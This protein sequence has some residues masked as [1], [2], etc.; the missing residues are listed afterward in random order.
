[1]TTKHVDRSYNRLANPVLEASL[2]DKAYSA[3]AATFIE[4]YQLGDFEKKFA[5]L[6]KRGRFRSLFPAYCS[7]IEAVATLPVFRRDLPSARHIAMARSHISNSCGAIEA[8]IHCR[9]TYEAHLLSGRYIEAIECLDKFSELHGESLWY[10]RTKILALARQGNSQLLQKFCDDVKARAKSHLVSTFTSYFQIIADADDA[11]LMLK[12]VILKEAEEFR[13]SGNVDLSAIISLYFSPAGMQVWRDF[14]AAIPLLQL[15]PVV[16]QYILLT[17]IL[18]AVSPA[19]YVRAPRPD[20]DVLRT[21]RSL[22]TTVSD[23]RLTRA[24]ALISSTPEH[25]TTPTGAALLSLYEK[26]RYGEVIETYEERYSQLVNPLAFSNVI[27]KALAYSGLTQLT[28]RR[29]IAAE[30]TEHL[31]R[32]QSLDPTQDHSTNQAISLAIQTKGLTLS[33]QVQAAL[34]MAAPLQRDPEDRRYIAALALVESREV[35]PRLKRLAVGDSKP[36]VLPISSEDDDAVPRYRSRKREI[37]LAIESMVEAGEIERLFSLYKEEAPLRRE[38]IELYA[39]YC[40]VNNRLPRLIELCGDTLTMD[41]ESYACFPM[42]AIIDYIDSNRVITLQALVAAFFHTK[43]GINRRDYLLNEMLEEYL[44]QREVARPS[45]LLM[46]QT[47]LSPIERL[48]YK[49]ICT[50]DVIDF[51]GCFESLNDLR[52]ERLLIVDLLLERGAIESIDRMREV[53]EIVGQ[54]IVDT[55]ASDLN[56]AKIYVDE[57]SIKRKLLPEVASS[58]LLYRQAKN[59]DDDRITLLDGAGRDE[60]TTSVYLSGSKNSIAIRLFNQLLHSFLFDERYGLDKNLST[61]IRHGFFSNLIRSKCEERH[62]LTESN[63]EGD[64]TPNA[65]WRDRYHFL[66]DEVWF[67]IDSSLKSFSSAF[68]ALVSKAEEWMKI[69][70]K[71]GQDQRVFAFDLE[72]NEFDDFRRDLD[73]CRG[74]EDLLDRAIRRLW[75]KTELV[76]SQI[77]ERLNV[78]FK[79]EMDEVFE[80]LVEAVTDAKRGAPLVELMGVIAQTKSDIKEDITRA[81]EWFR[82]SSEAER[83]SLPLTAV[84]GIAVSAFKEVRS[85]SLSIHT[86]IAAEIKGVPVKGEAV[87]PLVL[88]LINLL[89]NALRHSGLGLA[90]DVNIV[91]S[92]TDENSVLIEVSNDLSEAKL[93]AVG[94]HLHHLKRLLEVSASD[95]RLRTEGGSGLGKVRTLVDLTGPGNSVDLTLRG[96]RFIV[97]VR[98]D[99]DEAAAFD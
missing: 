35:T 8:L 76:M 64:Y 84:I 27:A 86:D 40:I 31:S 89:D 50:P 92:V 61:E 58:L 68:N 26:G 98:Y 37:V 62:L 12:N 73:E 75:V 45:E 97:G 66:L 72:L 43:K 30:L 18:C 2:P 46:G 69:R 54:I 82:R 95:P 39:E 93:Q 48:F 44:L 24:I 47:S 59:Q 91:G 71:V 80:R 42:E 83:E 15:F 25:V 16:D 9:G 78:E 49:D 13:E 99:G 56:S 3:L 11:A 22:S 36:G 23:E 1:M 4:G 88:A 29:G 21:M 38:Y 7:S 53:E 20:F 33:G 70:S 94:D 51:L 60:E 34:Y 74:P 14:C 10:V 85:N 32:I 96:G 65:F 79:S 67:D 17:D 19:I 28:H 52:A 81:S 63:A 6:L 87:K 5:S 57:T 90:T 41:S 77:R 55:G